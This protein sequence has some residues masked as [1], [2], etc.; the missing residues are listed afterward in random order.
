[1]DYYTP[2]SNGSDFIFPSDCNPVGPYGGQCWFGP[3]DGIVAIRQYMPPDSNLI[4]DPGAYVQST[5]ISALSVTL[6]NPFTLKYRCNFFW[7]RSLG[8]TSKTKIYGCNI[9]Q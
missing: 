5:N 8:F 6:A 4:V 9:Y 3:G 1:M 2:I 7:S